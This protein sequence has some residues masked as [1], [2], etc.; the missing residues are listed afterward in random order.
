MSDRPKYI[1]VDSGGCECAIVF[2]PILSHK[3]VAGY[4]PNSNRV[5][6]VWNIVTYPKKYV[7]ILVGG[8]TNRICRIDPPATILTG[9]TPPAKP[10]GK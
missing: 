4:T 3:Q 6:F 7:L 10:E 1:I 2:N 5:L 8:L 9:N